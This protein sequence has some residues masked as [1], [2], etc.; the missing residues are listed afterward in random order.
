M[1]TNFYSHILF[2]SLILLLVIAGFKTGQK[3]EFNFK[4]YFSHSND[5][6][7]E[8]KANKNYTKALDHFKWMEE[9]GNE[10]FPDNNDFLVASIC[11]VKLSDTTLA[12]EYLRKAVIKG[13]LYIDEESWA[14]RILGDKIVAV[15]RKEL[16]DLKRR[17]YESIAAQMSGRMQLKKYETIDQFVRSEAITKSLSPYEK[18]KLCHITD[19]VNISEFINA[20]KTNEVPP[21]C[22]LIYHL[23]DENQKYVPFI[24]SC[25]QATMNAGKLSP[26]GYAFWYDRQ[27]AYVEKIPQ[28]YGEYIEGYPAKLG[29][30][31]NLDS[32][33]FYRNEIGLPPLWQAAAEKDFELP[34][35]YKR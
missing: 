13:Y 35:G 12:I 31:A 24:D 22:L 34:S 26:A 15:V 23:Y 4:S 28:K 11:Y 20:V 7:Y 21:L 32:I 27:R 18:E 19:S 25:L 17:Y 2:P 14:T 33:D 1:K 3:N 9:N 10:K 16:P 5:F 29:K 6:Q 30:I 8:Y